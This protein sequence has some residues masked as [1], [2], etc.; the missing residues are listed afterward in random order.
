[1]TSVLPRELVKMYPH[2]FEIVCGNPYGLP[3]GK[4]FRGRYKE[5][6]ASP[7]PVELWGEARLYQMKREEVREVKE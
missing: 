5:G 7:Y 6:D 4:K 3:L 1:M 2:C